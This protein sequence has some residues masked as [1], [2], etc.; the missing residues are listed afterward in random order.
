MLISERQIGELLAPLGLPGR[1]DIAEIKQHNHV[2]RITSG[3]DV[4]FL[5]TYT[6]DWYGGDV[7]AT[8]G[9]VQH[10]RAA[11]AMLAAHG[12]S[13]PQLLLAEAGCD[14]PAG[15]PCLLTR[16]L[17]GAA[18][19][20]GE[21]EDVVGQL[22]AVGD[23]MRRMHAIEYER[24]GY[25]MPGGPQDNLVEGGWRHPL[26]DVDVWRQYAL[27]IADSERDQLPPAL[28]RRMRSQLERGAELLAP[29]YAQPRYTH[30]DCWPHQF[31]VAPRPERAEDGGWAVTGVIDME[32][33]SA[34]DAEADFVHVLIE[35]AAL[36]PARLHWWEPLFAG[37]GGAPDYERLRV[38]LLAA[39]AAEFRG[40][41]SGDLAGL[42]AYMLEARDWHELL[43]VERGLNDAVH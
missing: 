19:G 29:A 15:R 1:L 20:Q 5:K 24:P 32:V 35:L 39:S 12:L 41:W 34:G 33:A 26:W 38:R 18:L 27:D 37:Y 43:D 31:F 28:Y 11:W 21:P 4:L 30:G 16:G 13:T 17:A 7:A 22:R 10:E 14:N 40:M 8:G 23:Y 9:C 3:A 6:K 25:L 36:L 2:Y 42:R